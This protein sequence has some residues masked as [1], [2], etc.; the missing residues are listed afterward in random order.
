N[1]DITVDGKVILPRDTIHVART[2]F[3]WDGACY[4][5]LRLRSYLLHAVDLALSVSF[6]ADFADVFEVR[7]IG[8]PRRGLLQPPRIEGDAVVL[9]YQGLDGATRMT[10]LE[11]APGPSRLSASEAVWDVH[12]PPAG[13]VECQVTVRCGP[14]SDSRPLGYDAAARIAAAEVEAARCGEA[15]VHTSN[16]SFD[17]WLSR[18]AADLHMMLGET[19]EGPYPYAGVPW[20]STPFGRDGIITALEYLWVNPTIAAGVL[21]SLAATQATAVEPERDAQPGKILHEARLG[22]MAALGEVPFGR[23]Y[24]SVDATPLFVMLA[25]AYYTRTADLALVGKLW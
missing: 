2:A 14:R 25:G 3:L 15:R 18:S 9:A 17:A 1:A 16:H 22:E 24:G 20:F 13:E 4:I 23:Y 19:G 21:R 12:V 6:G 7:G 8:R 11:F 10:V 5:R